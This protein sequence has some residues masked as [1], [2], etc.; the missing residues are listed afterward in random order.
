M[1]CECKTYTESFE[2]SAWK[3]RALYIALGVNAA[4]FVFELLAGLWSGSTALQADSIDMLVDAAGFAIALAVFFRSARARAFAGLSN[5]LLEG[6]LALAVLGE[7]GWLATASVTPAGTVMV[8][9]AA[10]ALIANT[11]CGLLLMRFRDED[12]N[13]RSLWLCTRNDVIGNAGTI[14]A[15]AL[16][17]W[18][19]VKWPDL[20]MGAA[21]G[22]LQVRTS[23]AVVRD[24]FQ[25]LKQHKAD[26]NEA[27]NFSGQ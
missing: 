9:T 20:A 25:S 17:L 18:T 21:V 1:S 19:E 27:P 7:V 23:A 6:L 22:V 16:V 15:G 10:I 12:I 26:A 24:G 14:I 4:M 8:A 5:G 2:G 13:M 3:R 11:A